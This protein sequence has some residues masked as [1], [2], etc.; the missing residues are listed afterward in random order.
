MN[1]TP[2]DWNSWERADI[3]RHFIQKLR[4]VMSVTV[5][6]DVTDFLSSIRR[7]GLAFYPTMIWV[8]SAAVN[9]RPELRMGW[10]QRGT[11]GFWDIVSPYYAQFHRTDSRFV[12]LV[13]EYSPDFTVFYQRFQE[14]QDRF[15]SLRGFEQRELPPNTF[16]LSCL[17]WVHYRAFDMHIFDEGVYLAPVI[18]WGK[19]EETAPGR[20]TLPL[21]LNLHHAAGDGFHLCRFFSDVEEILGEFTQ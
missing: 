4:C 7:R 18:T 2:V 3:F 16:D 11:P 9:Q 19:Y 10:D 13:T 12:K 5:E 14:D 6:I 1:F 8:T 20:I 17:P 15:H 21:S